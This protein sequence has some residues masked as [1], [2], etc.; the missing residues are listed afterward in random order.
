MQSVVLWVTVI[1]FEPIIVRMERTLLILP[2]FAFKNF[3]VLAIVIA[4]F[5]VGI[6]VLIVNANGP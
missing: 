2:D 5:F 3:S 1:L 6:V 4:S